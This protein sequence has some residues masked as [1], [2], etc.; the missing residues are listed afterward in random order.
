MLKLNGYTSTFIDGWSVNPDG[1][2]V[3]LSLSGTTLTLTYA[4]GSSLGTSKMG[5]TAVT[6][7]DYAGG[8]IGALRNDDYASSLTIYEF[9]H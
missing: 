2:K 7:D 3:R 8:K 9:T 1:V 5:T 4:D 6:L